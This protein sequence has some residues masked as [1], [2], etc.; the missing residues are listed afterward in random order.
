LRKITTQ[1]WSYPCQLLI[2]A[3]MVPGRAGADTQ[4]VVHIPISQL[5]D[6][7]GAPELEDAWIQAKLGEP[8]YPGPYPPHGHPA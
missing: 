4:V 2:R 3:R 8:G 6:L 1:K 7:P 5:R